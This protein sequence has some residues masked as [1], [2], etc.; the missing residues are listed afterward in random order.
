MDADARAEFLGGCPLL[1]GVPPADLL[2]LAEAAQLRRYRRGQLLFSEGD[3]GDS[4]L[5]VVS[6]SLK[7][8]SPNAEGGELLLTVIERYQSVGELSVVDGGARSAS[9]SALSDAT[10]LRVPRETIL[11]V[12]AHS[13]ELSRALLDALASLIRRLTGSAADLAFLDIPRRVA[14]FVLTRVNGE[15]RP[16]ARL[17]QADMAAAIGASRQ[18]LNAAL[19]DFQRRGW[20]TVRPGE[21]ELRDAEALRRFVGG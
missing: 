16:A 3:A 17:T 7:A 18:S 4:L 5:V 6:G 14:K 10:V 11:A 19:Q 20:I 13:T 21:I 8:F 9:V 2:R 12:A 15:G 1:R